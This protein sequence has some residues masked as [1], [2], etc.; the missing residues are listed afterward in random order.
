MKKIVTALCSFILVLTL[1]GCNSASTT[2]KNILRLAQSESATSLNILRTST[3]V[4]YNVVTNVSE[5]LLQYNQAGILT[6]AI[7]NTWEK[8]ADGLTYTFNLREATWEDGTPITAQ[9]FVYAF[10]TRL[11]DDKSVYKHYL[12]YLK[13]GTAINKGEKEVTELG[14]Q[15]ITDHQLQIELEAPKTFFLDMLVFPAFFPLNEQFITSVGLDNYGTSTETFLANGAY[16]LSQFTPQEG[17]HYQKNANYWNA[18][19][20]AISE[21]DVRVV[22]EPQTQR[23]LWEQK[24]IDILTLSSDDI[25]TYRADPLLHQ[26]LTPRINYFY[27]SNTT[28]KPNDL[29]ANKN[30]RAAIAHSIDKELIVN[31]LLKD[32]SVAADY[33]VSE[34][35]LQHDQQDF[36]TFSPNFKE[37]TYQLELA[38]QFFQ[39]AQQELAIPA[40]EFV[41]DLALSDVPLTKKI[42]ENV[43]AQIETALPGVKV[44]LVTTPISTY[45]PMLYEHATPAAVSQLE[46]AYKDIEGFLYLFQTGLSQNFANWSNAEFDALYKQAESLELAD[47]TTARWQTYADM[48][49]ILVEDYTIIP[50]YQ[51]GTSY[52]IRE[53]IEGYSINPTVP[54]INYQHLTIK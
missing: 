49:K 9:D 3:A 53:D 8:S 36:R 6:G 32:G 23:I 21:I 41:F 10:H 28:A 20:V 26:S 19:N 25:E 22:P 14:I 44:N 29:L 35:V 1:V 46:P 30:F 5:G 52:L 15:A 39:A 43:K 37:P 54:H 2:N 47:N 48:E 38:Q 7:A 16:T 40:E 18:A 13:N 12:A 50:L 42:Y 45:F 24:E 34:G 17:W 4:N 31:S 11:Q 33:F 51:S 27:L